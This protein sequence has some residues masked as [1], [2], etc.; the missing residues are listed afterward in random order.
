MVAMVKPM[1]IE[2]KP[3]SNIAQI[4]KFEDF[5]AREVLG[6]GE[7][8]VP[9][10]T[11]KRR[12]GKSGP[13][14]ERRVI[15]EIVPAG[16]LRPPMGIKQR[17][18]CKGLRGLCQAQRCAVKGSRYRAPGVH[19]LDRIGYADHWNSRRAPVYGCYRARYE[20]SRDERARSIVHEDEL[21]I[22][23]L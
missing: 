20:G 6:R 8:D 9:D 18:E 16:P 23:G 21:G 3:G 13:L 19:C 7:L 2:A 17:G 4:G 12:D 14:H 11:V 22:V 10:L 1:D 5:C 15:G